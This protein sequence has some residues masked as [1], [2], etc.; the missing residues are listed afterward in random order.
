MGEFIYCLNK[1][2]SFSKS[3]LKDTSFDKENSA[4]LCEDTNQKVFDFDEIVKK[5]YPK[6]QPASY[7]TLLID[8]KNIYCIEFK[9]QKYSNI[10]RK[11]IIKKL[12]NS[13]DVMKELFKEENTDITNYKFIYCVAYKNSQAKWQRGIKKNETQFGLESYRG[14]F[15]DEVFTNDIDFFK[16]E[17]KKKFE[18]DLKC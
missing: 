6:K 15:Y 9:N 11:Q 3:T 14:D 2:Y 16:N 5:K 1:N 8:N 4:Y 12:E 13:K 10:D 18:K 17:Y 7:D